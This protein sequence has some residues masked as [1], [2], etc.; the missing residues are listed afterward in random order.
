[1]PIVLIS[2][3][4]HGSGRILA[5]NLAEKTGWPLYS[6]EQVTEKAHETG[7]RLSRLETS[8]IKTPVISE[9]LSRE[10]ELY[11]ALV[12]KT[13]YE[14]AKDDNLIYCGRAGHLL[15]AGIPGF[16]RVGLFDSMESR[17]RKAAKE[18]NLP[19]EKAGEYLA[20]LDQDIEKWIRYVHRESHRN[21]STYDL[22]LSLEHISL[23]NASSIL[24]QTALLPD[25]ELTAENRKKLDDRCL[26]A[27]AKLRLARDP[28][29]AGLDLGVRAVNGVVT[30]T[31]MPRQESAARNI[32]RV[33]GD[34]EGCRETICTMAETNIL[35]IQESF[36]PNGENFD[37][38][39]SLAKRWGAAVELLLFDSENSRGVLSP[40][41][42]TE[43]LKDRSEKPY[44]GGVEDDDVSSSV[45]DKGLSKTVDELVA[46]GRSAG[47]FRLSGTA[48]DVIDAVKDNNNY[49]LIIMGN[50]FQSKGHETSIRETR[51]LGMVLKDKL[52]APV[53]NT[54]ELHSRFL[55][56]KTQALKLVA[57]ILAT[58]CIYGL[59]F[60]YQEPILKVLGGKLHMQFRWAASIG[61]GLF[62]PLVA[63]VYSTVTELILKLID[64]D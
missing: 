46:L 1:M 8:I 32:P 52:K 5:E 6:R 54:K 35:W 17:V 33:L 60:T 23:E 57:F 26:A 22:F 59:V 38:V 56:G 34:L 2:S 15:F 30:V 53:I 20:D 31:Y 7:I 13:L 41:E 45:D 10:K 4:P 21:G 55:F 47:G 48:R 40:M 14:K 62:I 61:V 63:F 37:Q 27:D 50:I 51:E 12:T 44:T 3:L 58:F 43:A 64:I 24:H 42:D 18:L 16:I 25:F 39:T 36:D 28:E 49:S 19:E 9:K 29:T 11:L